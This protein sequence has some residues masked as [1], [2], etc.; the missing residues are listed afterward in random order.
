MKAYVVTKTNDD[1]GYTSTELIGVFSTNAEA[2]RYCDRLDPKSLDYYVDDFE[3]DKLI[4][5]SEE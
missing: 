4:A 1:E 3:V 2:C 5:E